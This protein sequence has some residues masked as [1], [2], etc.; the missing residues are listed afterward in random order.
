MNGDIKKPKQLLNAF[1][2]LFIILQIDKILRY[3]THN[4]ESTSFIGKIAPNNYQY[5]PNTIRKFKIN[6]ICL[7]GDI[8]DYV[9]HFLYFGFKDIAHERL[10]NLAKKDAIILDIGTNI[11]TT[12]LRFADRVGSNGYVYGFEPDVINYKS[13]FKNISLNNFSNIEVNNIGLGDSNNV[14]LLVVDTP[15]NRGGNRIVI[16][17]TTNKESIEIKVQKLDDWITSKDISKINVIKI[18]VEGFEFKV[19]KGGIETIQKFKP[20][21]FI[22]LDDNNLKAVGNSAK[23]L[24]ALVESLNYSIINAENNAAVYADQSFTNCHFDILCTPK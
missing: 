13:C 21:M 7:E 16:G 1:R 6:D 10:L 24:I 22:E 4:K 15:T 23:E 19:L 20:I 18:D 9:A 2:S 8:S 12:L 5:K 3:F 11:G 17:N 14:F